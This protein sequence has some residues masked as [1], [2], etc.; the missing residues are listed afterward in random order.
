MSLVFIVRRSG[1][2][3]PAEPAQLPTARAAAALLLTAVSL[4]L[5]ISEVGAQITPVDTIGI[6]YPG[7]QSSDQVAPRITVE[8]SYD[9]VGKLWSYRYTVANDTSARQAIWKVDLGVD[10][11]AAPSAPLTAIAP[12][13]WRGLVWPYS[14]RAYQGGATFFALFADDSLGPASGPPPARIPPG[15]SV[16]GFMIMSPYPPG[17]ARTYVQGYVELPPIEDAGDVHT[18]PDTTNSQRGFTIFPNQYVWTSSTAPSGASAG[19]G[20]AGLVGTMIPV[21]S[22]KV[23]G[24]VAPQEAVPI[25]VKLAPRSGQV[26]P[27]TFRVTLNGVDVTRAFHSARRGGAD[28]A[29]VF[30]RGASPL[31]VGENRLV[32]AVE[33][34]DPRTGGSIIDTAEL[35]FTVRP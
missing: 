18:P 35:R 25:A 4:L 26:D 6:N 22:A 20:A 7:W 29:A 2:K 17:Y 28:F 16:S 24:G 15:G 11:L 33:G 9:S 5:S 23:R 21:S 19:V 31:V 10:P 13:N 32:A 1:S 3:Q 30:R 27:T 12:V 14:P 34:V 8:T